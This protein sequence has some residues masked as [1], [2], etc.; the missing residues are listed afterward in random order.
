MKPI[1]W[2]VMSLA[3]AWAG[4]NLALAKGSKV[5]FCIGGHPAAETRDLLAQ[6]QALAA[7]GDDA[8]LQG[9]RATGKVL[10]PEGAQAAGVQCGADGLCQVTVFG[11]RLWM[12]KD[13][14]QC[15]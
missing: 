13:G 14:L 15:P 10:V 8:G 3:L 6:A 9:L 7:R 4:P 12:A 11:K 2:I 5:C 1:L